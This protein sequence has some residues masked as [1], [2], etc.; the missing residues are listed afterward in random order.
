MLM[1]E[2]ILK[3]GGN[4]VKEAGVTRIN[5]KDI[6]STI[7]HVS[8]LTGVPKKDLIP[9]GS[10]G[11][12]ATS[13]D[14]D[15]AVDINKYDPA[16]IHAKMMKAVDGEGVLNKATKIGSYAVPIRGNAEKG[17]VQVDL[18]Y[19]PN[20]E[21]AQFSYYSEGEG[22]KYKGSV[23]TLLLMGVAAALN[24]KGTDHFSYSKDGELIIR[25][26]RTLDLNQGLRRIFQHRPKKKKGDGYLKT[27]KSIPIEDF[28][29]QFP[30]VEVK[31]GQVIVD[32]PEKVVKAL[33]G[34]G[35]TPNDVRT[36]EQV[37]HLIKKKFDEEQQKRI[38]QFA[39]SRIGDKLGKSVRLPRELQDET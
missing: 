25:A 37:L 13:G 10:T 11:K 15:L 20:T 28:K 14:I 35:V 9:L 24:Q 12:A 7:T 18:M 22:S 17:K 26:G 23:R 32:S 38:F 6:P 27:M 3:E 39:K 5:K 1:Q 29:K 34:S 21:Y 30:D 2:L 36:A 19:V 8:K 16:E 33:F 31:G 4:A